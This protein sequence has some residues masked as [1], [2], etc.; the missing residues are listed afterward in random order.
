MFISK[1]GLVSGSVHRA[2]LAAAYETATDKAVRA[3]LAAC[4]AEHGMYVEG[5]KLVDPSAEEPAAAP[6]PEPEPSG[7]PAVADNKAAW[8]DWAVSE[9]AD[10]E[11]AEALTKAELVE[12]YGDK[13]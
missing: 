11:E 13:G 1:E 5:D 8:I 10:R 2:D 9:G 7:S 3:N 4:G 6:E 12:F